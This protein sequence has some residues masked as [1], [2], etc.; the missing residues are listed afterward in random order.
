MVKWLSRWRSPFLAT[1]QSSVACSITLYK[2]LLP[3]HYLRHRLIFRHPSPLPGWQVSWLLT[4]SSIL[5]CEQRRVAARRCHHG[6]HCHPCTM[7]DYTIPIRSR[8]VP[9]FFSLTPPLASGSSSCDR[10]HHTL[11]THTSLCRNSSP[12]PTNR[13]KIK[14]TTSSWE[15]RHTHDCIC[16]CECITMT[17]SAVNTFTN[18]KAVVHRKAAPEIIIHNHEGRTFP[19]LMRRGASVG[20]LAS[21]RKHVSSW[22]A[23]EE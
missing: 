2:K 16:I 18:V 13:L 12:L 20:V 7:I 17:N 19:L 6:H 8:T 11:L 3:G 21:M 23:R 22:H 9:I 1:F 10:D 14:I 15:F 4:P 5:I